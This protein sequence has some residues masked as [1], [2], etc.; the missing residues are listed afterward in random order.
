MVLQK[1]HVY[2]P[3]HIYSIT[4][5]TELNLKMAVFLKFNWAYGASKTN[6]HYQLHWS[7]SVFETDRYDSIDMSILYSVFIPSLQLLYYIVSLLAKV[8]WKN[9]LT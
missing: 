1:S 9:I 6:K 2:D 8:L 5:A 4:Y 3:N 7:T